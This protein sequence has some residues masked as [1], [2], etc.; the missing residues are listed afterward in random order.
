MLTPKL[1]SWNVE[2]HLGILLQFSG[3]HADVS[4]PY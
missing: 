4:T 3:L 1:F 2:V